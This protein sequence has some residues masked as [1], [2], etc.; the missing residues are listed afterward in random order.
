MAKIIRLIAIRDSDG[1]AYVT[2]RGTF[3]EVRPPYIGHNVEL[4]DNNT[5]AKGIIE[6]GFRPLVDQGESDFFS[7]WEALFESLSRRTMEMPRDPKRKR[8]TSQEKEEY[9]IAMPQLWIEECIRFVDQKLVGSNSHVLAHKALNI[10]AESKAI[11]EISDLRQKLARVR[12]TL[13]LREYELKHRTKP[14][15]KVV[16]ADIDPGATPGAVN[17]RANLMGRV[18]EK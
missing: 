8:A 18:I 10:L 17:E 15:N 4:T 14:K 16:Y 12:D 5:I 2:D 6:Y 9:V 3:Y 11:Q 1:W 13:A 7:D